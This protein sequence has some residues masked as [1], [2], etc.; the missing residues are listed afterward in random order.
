MAVGRSKITWHTNHH[1]NYYQQQPQQESNFIKCL[2][3]CVGSSCTLP[4]PQPGVAHFDSMHKIIHIYSEDLGPV[5]TSLYWE[6]DCNCLVLF[7]VREAMAISQWPHHRV[8]PQFQTYPIWA[9]V[10]RQ[11][12]LDGDSA[13]FMSMVWCS[14]SGSLTYIH[15]YKLL[16]QK[17]S[18][19]C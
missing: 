16:V 12:K 1:N 13:A 19:V 6:V 9:C 5:E 18:L 2:C 14:C 3:I 7:G 8:V 10:H 4:H 15:T 11:A 17:T